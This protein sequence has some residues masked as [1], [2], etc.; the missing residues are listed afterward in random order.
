MRYLTF[1]T[2]NTLY[3]F[4]PEKIDEI[5]HIIWELNHSLAVFSLKSYGILEEVPKNTL[6]LAQKDAVEY[7]KALN[8]IYEKE[9]PLNLSDFLLV[10]TLSKIND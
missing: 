8:S 9:I 10:P 7:L 2:N 6:K 5:F 4:T 3:S 1:L